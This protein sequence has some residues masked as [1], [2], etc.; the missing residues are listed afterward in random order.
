MESILIIGQLPPP[1]TG[2]SIS[3]ELVISA[4]KKQYK[5]IIID[6]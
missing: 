3:N 1:I 5:V 6:S 2:E 4:L